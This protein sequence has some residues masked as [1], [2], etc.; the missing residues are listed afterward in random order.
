MCGW[1]LRP[2]A[3]ISLLHRINLIKRSPFAR[4]LIDLLAK[5][6]IHRRSSRLSSSA[7]ITHC[8]CSSELRLAPD[9]CSEDCANSGSSCF[10]F[11]YASFH[12]ASADQGGRVGFCGDE[13]GTAATL[14]GGT[15]EVAVVEAVVVEEV[16]VKGVVVKGVVVEGV[17]VARVTASVVRG[18]SMVLFPSLEALPVLRFTNFLSLSILLPKFSLKYKKTFGLLRR[19]AGCDCESTAA[20]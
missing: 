9:A 2:S 20:D 8:T 15:V 17:V 14:E 4:T 5:A 6:T 19:L 7:L 3:I 1:L 12:N 18:C 10:S 16:V 11:S 13:I